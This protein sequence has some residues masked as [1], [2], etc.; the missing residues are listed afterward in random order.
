M[1]SSPA[2]NF[3]STARKLQRTE[4][5]SFEVLP[6]GRNADGTKT[7]SQAVVLFAKLV[8]AGILIF[9]CIGVIRITL[10]SATVALA[11]ESKQIDRQIEEVRDEG[12]ALEVERSSLSNP[13]R[14]KSEASAIG[15]RLPGDTKFMDLSGD[16]V[17]TDKYGNLSL[18]K[19]VQ[20]ASENQT[21]Q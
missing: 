8:I 3:G 15:M 11:M 18:S 2:Y 10:S 19:S 7:A 12:S 1:N 4:E 16:V 6:G 17:I 21:A 14:I 5:P 20:A 9:A 13:T